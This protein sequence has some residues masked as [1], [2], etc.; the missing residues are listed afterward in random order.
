VGPI[1][2][3]GIS[4]SPLSVPDIYASV[5]GVPTA[6]GIA[7][8]AGVVRDQDH[9]RPVTELG[10]SAHP[11]AEASLRAVVEKAIADYPVH[12]VSAVHRVGDLAI[13]DTAVVVAVACP[14]R[15]EA[16]AACHQIIDE[17]KT[18]VPIWKNQRFADGDAEWVGLD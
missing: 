1:R 9:G 4:S 17:I 11:S 8:F 13:G 2:K 3:L 16:F 5:C 18:T 12:A 14:G 7:L 10:Y 15:A 6:G